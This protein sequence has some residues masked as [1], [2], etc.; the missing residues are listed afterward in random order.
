MILNRVPAKLECVAE[1]YDFPASHKTA[2]LKSELN[3]AELRN[4]G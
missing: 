4:K 2:D 3:G 1:V